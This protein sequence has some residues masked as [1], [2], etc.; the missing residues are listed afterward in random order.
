MVTEQ[1]IRIENNEYLEDVIEAQALVDDVVELVR[2]K[3]ADFDILAI[4]DDDSETFELLCEGDTS[5]ILWFDNTEKQKNLR[6]LPPKDFNDL[7]VFNALYS[8]VFTQSAIDQFIAWRRNPE[9]IVSLDPSLDEILRPTFGLF[10][11]YEQVVQAIQIF[12]G[13]ESVHAEHLRKLMCKDRWSELSIEQDAFVVGA[14]AI[15]HTED[16]ARNVFRILHDNVKDCKKRVYWAAYTM[17]SYRLAYL[18]AHYPVEFAA[19]VNSTN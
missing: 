1:T 7:L 19:A 4:Q 10:V 8:S 11:F 18:K 3:H 12:A 6:R 2:K 15:G 14:M 13:F 5:S 9:S 16:H 17:I